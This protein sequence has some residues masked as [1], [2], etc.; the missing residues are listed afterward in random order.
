MILV[1]TSI[2]IDHLRSGNTAL[3][4]LLD[5]GAVLGHP[6]V[7]GE[8]V[9]GRLSKRQEVLRLLRNLPTANVATPDELLLFI[10]R[11]QLAGH[12]IGYVDA[13]LLAA[14]RMTPDAQ[15]WT[16][17]KHLSTAAARLGLAVDR[18]ALSREH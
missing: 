17:D 9:L 1:D 13:Q 10:E 18:E 5:R 11:R 4:R 16:S 7:I 14:A 3:A 15:L 2:W 12:G 8:L 6:W